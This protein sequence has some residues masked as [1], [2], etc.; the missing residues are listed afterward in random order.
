MPTYEVQKRLLEAT[1]TYEDI[2]REY[3]IPINIVDVSV[4]EIPSEEVVWN[5]MVADRFIRTGIPRHSSFDKRVV[6]A[7]GRANI[8]ASGLN[9]AEI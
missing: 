1:A 8:L 6:R 3:A 5:K 7:I 2:D 9:G 4:V